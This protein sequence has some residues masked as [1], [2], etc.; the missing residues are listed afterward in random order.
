MSS[1]TSFFHCRWDLWGIWCPLGQSHP[2]VLADNW[3]MFANGKAIS[4]LGEKQWKRHVQ[5]S[6]LIQHAEE[7][8]EVFPSTFILSAPLLCPHPYSLQPFFNFSI[9]LYRHIVLVDRQQVDWKVIYRSC[10]LLFPYRK[11]NP[12]VWL[13]HKANYK[14]SKGTFY[15]P[16]KLS[17]R[18]VDGLAGVPHVSLPR[19]N[20]SVSKL[21]H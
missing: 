11:R 7:K 6:P 9:S 2:A 1:K 3:H 16:A 14:R 17:V 21:L 4:G 13:T 20:I 18:D 19:S 10:N 8:Q 12:K 5:K 15:Q